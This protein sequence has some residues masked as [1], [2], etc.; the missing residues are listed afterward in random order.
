MSR[1]LIGRLGECELVGSLNKIKT[2]GVEGLE[3]LV[4]V[5]VDVCVGAYK[6]ML[7]LERNHPPFRVK[8]VG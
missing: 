4:P 8:G 7:V 1:C 6:L 3:E 2:T 5:F